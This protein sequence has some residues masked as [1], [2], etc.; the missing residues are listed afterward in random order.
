MSLTQNCHFMKFRCAVI[1]EDR[2]PDVA[3]VGSSAVAVVE[4]PIKNDE[5]KWTL[6]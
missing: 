4:I 1:G 3:M 5:L 6:V 2:R